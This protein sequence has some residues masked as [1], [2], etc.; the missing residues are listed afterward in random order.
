MRPT[1]LSYKIQIRIQE[2]GNY[3]PIFLMNVD[4]KILNLVLTN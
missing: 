3:T 2:E 4:A 1:F